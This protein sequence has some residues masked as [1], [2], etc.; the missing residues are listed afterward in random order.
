MRLHRLVM[1]AFGPFAQRVDIDFDAVGEAGIF[2]VHGPTGAG[3]TSLLDGICFALYAGAPGSRP[4]G[5]SLRS[6][7]AQRADVPLVE[8]EFTASGRRLRVRRS[9]EHLR[10]KRRGIGDTPVP[11]SATLEEFLGGAW[12]P[13]ASGA[14]DV[15]LVVKDVLGLGLEQFAKVVLLPQGEFAAFLRA[16]AE[17]RRDLLERL[18]DVSR[19][20][21]IEAWLAAARRDGAQALVRHESALHQVSARL[22]DIVLRLAPG[23]VELPGEWS[24]LPV[25]AVDESVAGV[26]AALSRHGATTLAERDVAETQDRSAQRALSAA[27]RV[28]GDRLKGESARCVLDG[29]D[30]RRGELDAARD[31]LA[32]HR[33]AAPVQGALDGRERAHRAAREASEALEFALRGLPGLAVPREPALAQ[34]LARSVTDHDR[35][36]GDIERGL[37]RRE[38]ALRR[39]VA[40]QEALAAAEI[41]CAEAEQARD[42][43]AAR[44]A[45]LAGVLDR[46]PATRLALVRAT[47]AREQSQRTLTARRRLDELTTTLETAAQAVEEAREVE[48][49]RRDDWLSLRQRHLDGMSARL[50]GQLHEGHPCPVCGSP[51]HPAPA[52]SADLVGDD[53][54]AAAESAASEAAARLAEATTRLAQ[55]RA[56]QADAL[57]AL[58]GLTVSAAGALAALQADEQRVEQ[59]TAE[60]AQ[61][62]ARA[63][64]D[65]EQHLTAELTAADERLARARTAAMQARAQVSSEDVEVGRCSHDLDADLTR[66]TDSCPCAGAPGH[67]VAAIVATHRSVAAG[68]RALQQALEA[69]SAADALALAADRAAEQAAHRHG[70]DSAASA[71]AAIL[72]DDRATGLEATVRQAERAAT[73]ARTVLADPDVASALAAPAPDLAAVTGLA[74]AAAARRREAERA[75]ADAEAAY[76]DAV[77]LRGELVEAAKTL[78]LA[79]ARH[80]TVS[81]LADALGG[82]GCDNTLRMRLSAFVLAAR[83]ERVVALAN[84]RLVRLGDG[85]YRLVHSDEPAAGGRRSGLGL[86]VQDLWTGQDRDT[87]TLSGG[88]SFMASLALALGLADAVREESGGA[89]LQTLVVDEGFG[90]LDDESLEQVMAVLDD[91]RDGGRCVGVVSHVAD[92]RTRITSQVHVAKTATGSTVRVQVGDAAGAA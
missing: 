18:F 5:R 54:L 72:P 24:T 92:L 85:R 58:D 78:R 55:V 60:L 23:A 38:A 53:A 49:A 22:G 68:S 40:A 21:D 26:V 84:E 16:N 6:D 37:G 28:L 30:A 31:W 91:L 76:R 73:Q 80:D 66:H 8:L 35:L 61:G 79:R 44:R 25:E 67:D 57:E 59:L 41:A 65:D 33:R 48:L 27:E 15:G 19:F 71:A 69:Q 11:A 34:A 82:L 47:A 86:R 7:H 29:L 77:A 52:R 42:A 56:R 20:T 50:A 13:L 70:F 1:A 12:V 10:P 36:V 45:E 62:Q 83:L 2:L 9:P 17:Q 88:E 32:G 4:A 46:L 89:D 90:T 39:R 51:Q 63:G 14:H 64:R 43:A 3:K 74:D 75:H 87:A 81:R